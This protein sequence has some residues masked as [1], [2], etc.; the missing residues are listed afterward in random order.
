ME[1][2]QQ[3]SCILKL[4]SD[5]SYEF[6]SCFRL[7]VN[8][9]ETTLAPES[10]PVTL[11]DLKPGYNYSVFVEAKQFQED[12]Q[13]ATV[14]FTIPLGMYFNENRAEIAKKEL[15][16]APWG[17]L[18]LYLHYAVDPIIQEILWI[19]TDNLKS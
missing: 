13:S 14:N 9:V 5:C 11:N 12:I 3:R 17:R 8:G 1:R 16:F 15:R 19:K 7:F 4:A 6:K 2:T 10:Y 18:N